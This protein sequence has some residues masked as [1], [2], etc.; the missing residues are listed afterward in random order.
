MRF[1][2]RFTEQTINVLEL[3]Q[4]AATELGHANVGTEHILLGIVRDGASVA[5]QVLSDEG[6]DEK[7]I[8]ALIVKSV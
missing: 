7:L 3:A 8:Y 5:A 1:E 2:D 4:T 6:L